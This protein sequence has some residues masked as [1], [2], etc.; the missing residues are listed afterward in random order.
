M[1]TRQQ[2]IKALKKNAD[3]LYQIKLI[4]EKPFSAVSGDPTEVIHHYVRKSQ[5]NALRYDYD[6]GV[7]LTNSEHFKLHKTGDPDIFAKILNHYG[8]E[9][10][11]DLQVRRHILTRIN[12]G[13][14]K[15]IIVDLENIYYF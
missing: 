6:N 13:Y 14:L 4:A 8:Q 3:K 7:P 5:S 1:A 12:K 11:D 15:E 2:S 10:H 9:W